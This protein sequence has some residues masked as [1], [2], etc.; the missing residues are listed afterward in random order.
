[1]EK[2][3]KG[4][5]QVTVYLLRKILLIDLAIG[6]GVAISFIFT[7]RFTFLAY[8]ERM[9]W[10]GIAVIMTGG[11]I[12][13]AVMMTVRDYGIPG[14]VRK[15]EEAKDILDRHLEIRQEREQRFDASARLWLIGI[16]C[17]AISA[18]VQVLLT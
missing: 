5:A 16:G 17:I 15:P 9:F 1:M 13:L 12:M 7:G 14:R 8:S 3:K 11:T 2:I 4:I 10:A 18:L 6:V